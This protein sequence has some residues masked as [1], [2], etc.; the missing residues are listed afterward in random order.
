MIS[1]TFSNLLCRTEFLWA[2]Y[3]YDDLS[4]MGYSLNLP[5]YHDSSV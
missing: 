3:D 5:A 2:G 1:W 4:V